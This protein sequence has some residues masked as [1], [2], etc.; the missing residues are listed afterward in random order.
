VGVKFRAHAV[1]CSDC[2][3]E[4]CE[5]EFARRELA[6]SD[7]DARYVADDDADAIDDDDVACV[8]YGFGMAGGQA[9]PEMRPL[10]RKAWSRRFARGLPVDDDDDGG[11]D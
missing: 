7:D 2:V 6:D 4:I 10:M 5:Q 1:F 11:D 8:D 3:A 9:R